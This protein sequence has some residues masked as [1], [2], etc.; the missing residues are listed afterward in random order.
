MKRFEIL[1]MI[2]WPI[3][4]WVLLLHN[5]NFGQ[6]LFG[7]PQVSLVETLSKTSLSNLRYTYKLVIFG[8]FHPKLGKISEMN[9]L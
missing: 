6:L 2:D 5:D 1:Q 8:M 9:K 7:Q 3:Q 4:Q